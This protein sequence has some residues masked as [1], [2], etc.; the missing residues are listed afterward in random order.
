MSYSLAAAQLLDDLAN[1]TPFNLKQDS[2]FS[3]LSRLSQD[4][5]WIL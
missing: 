3:S 5:V 2:L 4:V 1:A